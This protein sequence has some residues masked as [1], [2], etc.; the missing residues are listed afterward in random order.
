M[1][2]PSGKK[3]TLTTSTSI[4]TRLAKPNK[5]NAKREKY[6]RPSTVEAEAKPTKVMLLC[7]IITSFLNS[8][9]VNSKFFV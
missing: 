1:N 3:R 8:F 2:C 7:K 5:T 4:E 6:T 9:H